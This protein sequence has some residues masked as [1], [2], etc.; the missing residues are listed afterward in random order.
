[1]MGSK[2]KSYISSR[3]SS[4]WQSCLKSFDHPKLECIGIL[5]LCAPNG[6]SKKTIVWH[7][8]ANCLDKSRTWIIARDYNMVED[9]S[10][11]RGG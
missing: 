10:D 6:A 2:L 11:R 7:E 4:I 1:M 3:D 5:A 8:L 9:I